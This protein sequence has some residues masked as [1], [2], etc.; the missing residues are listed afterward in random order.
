MA[1]HIYVYNCQTE[2][3]AGL[4]SRAATG[5]TNDLSASRRPFSQPT[6]SAALSETYPRKLSSEG[7]DPATV[8]L[9]ADTSSGPEVNSSTIKGASNVEEAQTDKGAYAINISSAS[10][11]GSPTATTGYTMNRLESVGDKDGSGSQVSKKKTVAESGGRVEGRLEG[12][13]GEDVE[14]Y[15]QMKPGYDNE[16][17][18]GFSVDSIHNHRSQED[19]VRDYEQQLEELRGQLAKVMEEKENLQQD[20]ERVSAQWEGKVRRLKMKLKQQKGEGEGE[21]RTGQRYYSN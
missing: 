15:V 6:T 16:R 18:D 4:Q 13:G 8:K 20:R 3:P 17:L 14:G 9:T 5:P 19:V 10:T 1:G 12:V 2:C 21:V 7:F 11:I